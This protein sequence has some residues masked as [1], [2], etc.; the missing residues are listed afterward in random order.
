MHAA[1]EIRGSVDPMHAYGGRAE[2][3]RLDTTRL[4]I[5]TWPV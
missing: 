1:G 5:E 4:G 3:A 2:R